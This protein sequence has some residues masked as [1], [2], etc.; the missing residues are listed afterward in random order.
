MSAT[1]YVP[2]HTFK[3][4]HSG[5]V[6]ALAFAPSGRYLASGSDDQQVIIWAMSSGT[7]LYR[8]GFESAVDAL[9]WHPRWQDTLIVACE[10]GSLAQLCGLTLVCP[11]TTGLWSGVDAYTI[12]GVG[13]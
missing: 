1:A 2:V 10:N 4:G 12:C 9:L 5:N 7:Q 11:H 3:G 6:N 13:L 8:I